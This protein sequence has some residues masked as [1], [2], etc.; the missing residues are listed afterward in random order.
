MG[1]EKTGFDEPLR[2]PLSAFVG[3]SMGLWGSQ[4]ECCVCVCA[5]MRVCVCTPVCWPVCVWVHTYACARIH[6]SPLRAAICR[7]FCRDERVALVLCDPVSV[8]KP[9]LLLRSAFFTQGDSTISHAGFQAANS[10][11]SY[12]A[13]YSFRNPNGI[14]FNK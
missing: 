11:P 12:S 5:H 1:F 3:C 10:F 2:S 6:S 8:G 14:G 4:R 7:T 9:T 13:F